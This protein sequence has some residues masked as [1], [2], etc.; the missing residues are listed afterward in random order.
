MVEII[1]RSVVKLPFRWM[2]SAK[3]CSNIWQFS[4]LCKWPFICCYI[5]CG[6]LTM[7]Q[8][9]RLELASPFGGKLDSI[10]G[11][12]VYCAEVSARYGNAR[13][14]C[15]NC[16]GRTVDY[17]TRWRSWFRHYVSSRKVAGSLSDEIVWIFGVNSGSNRNEYQGYIL[18]G[19]CGRYL[20]LT[21]LPPSC[22]DCLEILGASTF[23]SPKGL[24]WSLMEYHYLYRTAF[25]HSF[26]CLSCDRSVSSSDAIS[27]VS[28]HSLSFSYCFYSKHN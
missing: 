13:I 21:T 14:I 25:I 7:L 15:L 11:A 20:W 16:R 1:H 27:S 19:K 26:R 10:P 18:P 24:S 4:W 28:A 6:P 8:I 5:L 2:F 22:S 17:V 9:S 12:N 3:S 23:W